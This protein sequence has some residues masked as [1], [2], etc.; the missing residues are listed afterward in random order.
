MRQSSTRKGNGK[1]HETAHAAARANVHP[2]A[3]SRVRWLRKLRNGAAALA[4]AADDAR[5]HR[6]DARRVRHPERLHSLRSSVLL[7]VGVDA[8]NR[9]RLE[10]SLDLL[11]EV[12]ALRAAW[13]YVPGCGCGCSALA[14][15][16]ERLA[17]HDS[18]ARAR[19][20]VRQ[21]SIFD[22]LGRSAGPPSTAPSSI[23]GTG[24][25]TPG[26]KKVGSTPT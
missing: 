17:Q 16:E 21:L 20:D 24:Q 4:V 12:N 9:R 19:S 10:L 1:K 7:V 13:A 25:A 5:A 3:L 18:D 22:A 23:R 2:G 8:M 26:F 15:A 11:R 6:A 14:L